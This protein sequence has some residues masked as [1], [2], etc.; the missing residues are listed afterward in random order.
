MKIDICIEYVMNRY[1]YYSPIL[2][3]LGSFPIGKSLKIEE[4][5]IPSG[6]LH[7][8]YAEMKETKFQGKIIDFLCWVSSANLIFLNTFAAEIG[9]IP[10]SDHNFGILLARFQIMRE[11]HGDTFSADINNFI[12]LAYNQPDYILALCKQFNCLP[13]IKYLKTREELIENLHALIDDILI[14]TRPQ[15]T[16]KTKKNQ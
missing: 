4:L 1:T 6:I 8:A 2:K 15:K 7:K 11:L 3:K 12:R 10:M 5:G 9:H 13:S 16:T 14:K